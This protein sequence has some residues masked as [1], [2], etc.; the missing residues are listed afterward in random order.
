MRRPIRVAVLKCDYPLPKTEEKYGTFGGLFK[1]LLGESTKALNRP[2]IIDPEAGLEVSEYD[3]VKEAYPALEDV[4]AILITGSKSDAFDST[5][6]I[7]KLVEFTAKALAQ[8]RVRVIGVCFGHQIIGRA[9]GVK[10]GRSD[11][12]WEAAVHPLTL[13]DKGKE[14]FGV[15]QLSI[16]EMHRDIVFDLPPNVVCLASTPKCAIQGM[17]S[18]RK[19]ISVQGHPEFDKDIVMEIMQT[20]KANY[21]PDVFDEAMKVIGNKQ[22]GVLIGQAFVKFLAEE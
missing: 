5:P 6:W 12:G 10:V 9:L 16:M 4:D 18:P 13:T 3:V 20:R 14:I 8:D 11:A 2:D 19:F 15:E 22:D 21:P 7:V 17:Y 1:F